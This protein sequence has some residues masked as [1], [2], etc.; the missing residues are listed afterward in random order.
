MPNVASTYQGFLAMC[1]DR[2][3]ITIVGGSDAARERLDAMTLVVR[4]AAGILARARQMG[5]ETTK[6]AFALCGMWIRLWEETA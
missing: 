6:D 1:S 5:L 2:Q 3:T 4:G